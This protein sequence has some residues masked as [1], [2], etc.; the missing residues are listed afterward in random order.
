MAISN[1]NHRWS[2]WAV[3]RK[4]SDGSVEE[5]RY[6]LICYELERRTSYPSISDVETSSKQKG[7]VNGILI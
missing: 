1:C 7:E 3:L 2:A 6:C 4:N 5:E